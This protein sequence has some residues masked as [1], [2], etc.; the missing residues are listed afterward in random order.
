M[1]CLRF[2]SLR[3]VL[4][5]HDP[6]RAG[7]AERRNRHRHRRPCPSDRDPARRHRL[8]SRQA[9]AGNAA[10]RHRGERHHHR[11]LWRHRGRY[12]DRDHAVGLHRQLLRRRRRGQSAR[13]AGGILFPRLQAGGQSRHLFHTLG[14]RGRDRDFARAAFGDLW[15]GQGGRAGQ[16]RAQERRRVR[17]QHR[18]W[19]SDRHL[20]QLFQTQP[21]AA[22]SARRSI[23]ARSR[24]VF[25]P[26]ARSTIPSASIAASIPA[27]SC[28][29]C[30]AISPMATGRCRPITCII[31]PMAMCRR[32]AGTG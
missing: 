23:W 18:L 25:M 15:R 3:F 17:R 29:N 1:R 8:R 11:P 5:G 20:W 12:P 2:I 19:R 7:A 6:A 10:R 4:P 28:W 31:I 32:R 13:H 16:F 30:P 27:I 22:R 21:D 14:R 9:A 24:A 26:M